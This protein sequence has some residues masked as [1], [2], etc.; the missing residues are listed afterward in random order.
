MAASASGRKPGIPGMTAAVTPSS[1]SSSSN[2]NL[3]SKGSISTSKSKAQ[4]KNEKRKEKRRED[5]AVSEDEEA[6]PVGTKEEVV[7]NWD[8]GEDTAPVMTTT[9]SIETK[10]EAVIE[11][12]RDP[13]EEGKKV[14]ALQKKL[15]QV[16]RG[17]SF[18]SSVITLTD[19]I[20]TSI[21]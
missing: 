3:N 8:D 9:T 20:C 14:K 4:K 5:G 6:G 18:L 2:L 19:K 12:V 11:T 13:I 10:V 15:R 7:D 17:Q 1:S 16:R 21:G